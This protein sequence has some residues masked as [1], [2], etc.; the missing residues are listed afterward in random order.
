V[1]LARQGP[2]RELIVH[3][4]G[5]PIAGA[6]VDVAQQVVQLRGRPG[7]DHAADQRA[8]VVDPV[9]L[10]VGDREVVGGRVVCRIEG[11]GPLER[12]D[13][14]RQPSRRQVELGERAVGGEAVGGGPRGGD[15]LLLDRG[16]GRS[17]R[18]RLRAERGADGQDDRDDE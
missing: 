18:R 8:C 11:P 1:F 17:G 12:R 6:H 7:R 2:R 14:F 9:G 4:R 3:R 15:E 5:S 13:R 10:E 16:R